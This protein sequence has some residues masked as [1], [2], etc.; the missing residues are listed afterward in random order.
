MSLL[1]GLTR[2]FTKEAGSVILTKLSLMKRST[3]TVDLT[4]RVGPL[5]TTIKSGDPTLKYQAESIKSVIW[6]G[7]FL[8]KK[9][10]HGSLQEITVFL[11]THGVS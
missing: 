3:C 9:K 10:Y 1:A 5:I 11:H 4:P 2:V 6:A 8:I 7:I